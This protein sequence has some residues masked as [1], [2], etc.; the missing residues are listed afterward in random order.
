MFYGVWADDK[1][2]GP[3]RFV[4]ADL[5]R[6]ILGDWI[7]GKLVESTSLDRS[8]DSAEKPSLQKVK[9]GKGVRRNVPVTRVKTSGNGTSG[10]RRKEAL[11]ED[12]VEELK[13]LVTCI[14]CFENK[15]NS[16]L[17]P[18]NH[19]CVCSGCANRLEACPICRTPIFERH[20]IYMA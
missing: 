11:D 6:E 16:L 1:R 10:A 13:D 19:F 4:F 18:C 14:V 2:N 3:G 12:A 5:G 20:A 9:I 17:V 8:V 15:R 7:D